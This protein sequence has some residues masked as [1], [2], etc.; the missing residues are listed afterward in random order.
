[1][2]LY[3]QALRLLRAC[4]N[5]LARSVEAATGAGRAALAA[6]VTALPG[7]VFGGIQP[8][9][10][11]GLFWY[12]NDL[13]A[14]ALDALVEGWLRLPTPVMDRSE[15]GPFYFVLHTVIHIVA[16]ADALAANRPTVPAS[17][18]GVRDCGPHGKRGAG[19]QMT[20]VA[21]PRPKAKL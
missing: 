6:K 2:G 13:G 17:V 7:D 4:L 9:L 19:G 3:R 8:L 11:Q 12:R 21:G 1:M 15:L 5:G 18:R 16:A 10:L 14:E 20:T